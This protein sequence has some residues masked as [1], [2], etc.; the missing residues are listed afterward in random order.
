[1]PF[2]GR[3][4]DGKPITAGGSDAAFNQDFANS[5]DWSQ[6]EALSFWVYGT[7]SGVPI[8][9]QVKDNRA[10]DPGPSGWSLVWSEE[11]DEPAGTLPNPDIWSYEIGDGSAN[12]IPGWGNDELQ[13]YTDDP[14]NAAMDGQGNL[15]ITLREA[16]GTLDCYYG[17]CEYTSARLITQNK[18]E[19]AYGRIESRLLVPDGGDG[20][21]PAF[22]SL[23]SDITENP[24]PGAGEIDFME[25]VSRI[26]NEIFG[27][28][29]GPGYNGG[30]AFG[31]IYDFGGPVSADYH[32]FAVE[33]QPNLIKWFVDGIQYH[34]ATPADVPGPWVF[35]KEFFLLLNF[36][37]GGNFG[38]TVDPTNVYPQEYAIDYIRVFQGPDTAERFETTITDDVA[39]WRKV[40]VPFA[41]FT[42]SADQPAG[43]PNDGLGLS[44]VWG[45]GFKLPQGGSFLFDD[46]RLEL[47]P[48]VLAITV[49]NLDDSGPGSLRQALVD[50][51]NGG[52]IS[53]DPSL[54]GQTIPLG[55]QIVINRDVVIDASA[56]PG[57]VVSGG[58]ASR[59]FQIDAGASVSMNDLVISDGAGQPQGGGVLNF[60]TLSLDRVVVSNNVESSAGPASFNLGGGGIYNGDGATLNLTDSTVSNNSTVAQ[61]GGGIYGFFNSTIN[62]TR[63]TVSNNVGG[64][65]AGGLRSLG[66][67]NVINS[68]FTGNT[69]TA[70]HGGAM[71]LTDGNITVSNSTI[72][73]NNSPANTAGGL[74]VAT[75]GAPVNVTIADNVI[76]D[77]G[78]YN[79][80]IEG[81]GTAVL[82]SSGGNVNTD[83]SCSLIAS[84]QDVG[85]GG[86]LVG[87]LTDN[88]GPTQTHA[89]SG[90]S[91]AVDSAVGSCP[92][93][94]QR[95]VARPQ[96]AG[97]DAGAFE[98]EP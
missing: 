85:A 1:L 37:I 48:P 27:T 5:K 89:L 41:D 38:G 2:N 28:V 59:V 53:F 95:G 40:E 55:S 82:A 97:C 78:T 56:A 4:F 16:D 24:W 34:Q 83:A 62:I 13:Y 12:G 73:G 17:P 6:G 60:G 50:I 46:V 15:V 79:C 25:Y 54:A 93:I 90:G 20:L 58:G 71:F 63:S 44:E 66:N 88:G 74:M 70:W 45:Y 3:T 39:G 64:D 86:A 51:G 29:H 49:T 8:T 19:F 81:G 26:P 61:P 80:Q 75:F 67:A 31:N 32:T 36:A 47:P 21:W 77:N 7:G 11:F 68:T 10:P 96:G 76:A 33:W 57:V 65:V 98:L 94:D 43:A 72:F 84:D 30:N 91:P 92:A 14:D 69:S 87:A 35:E 9:V 18:A 42:R 52:V 22:W 23:G